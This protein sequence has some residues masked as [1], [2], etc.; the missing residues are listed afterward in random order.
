LKIVK[1]RTSL[2]EGVFR[3]LLLPCIVLVVAAGLVSWETLRIEASVA[4]EPDFHDYYAV[5]EAKYRSH[6]TRLDSCTVCH[7]V[8][9]AGDPTGMNAYGSDLLTELQ[10]TVPGAAFTS[11]PDVEPP[12]GAGSC[13]D[14]LDN[15]G[16]TDIDRDDSDCQGSVEIGTDLQGDAHTIIYDALNAIAD[17]DSD[18]DGQPN[19][20][21]ITAL[22][23]PGDGSD[24]FEHVPAAPIAGPHG[25][26]LTDGPSYNYAPFQCATCH[27]TH[28]AEAPILLTSEPWGTGGLCYTCHSGVGA[29]TDVEDGVISSGVDAGSS[30]HGGGLVNAVMDTDVNGVEHPVSAPVTSTH[31][32]DGTPGLMWGSLSEEQDASGAGKINVTLDC[33]NCHDPH[34]AAIGYGENP[35][36]NDVTGDIDFA[37]ALADG[38]VTLNYRMLQPSPRESGGYEETMPYAPGRIPFMMAVPDGGLSGGSYTQSYYAADVTGTAHDVVRPETTYQPN[39][40]LVDW[41][42]I[43]HTRYQRVTVTQYHNGSADHGAITERLD[44]GPGV[45][46]DSDPIFTYGH[47]TSE[48]TCSTVSGCH[49]VGGNMPGEDYPT[50]FSRPRCLDC[51]VSHGTSAGQFLPSCETCHKGYDE[52][53]NHPG[54]CF[55]CHE[56]GLSSPGPN[57]A[58]WPDFELEDWYDIVS[59]WDLCIACHWPE[60]GEGDPWDFLGSEWANH[61]SLLRSDNRGVCTT[62]HQ[63]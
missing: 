52:P 41:C 59:S 2:G 23:F 42:S 34:G 33:G 30:I 8:D 47:A 22:S 36:D 43:C 54:E 32:V 50:A 46:A 48:A 51:H 13:N 40:R 38:R 9:G 49:T 39:D 26:Y 31:T 62:C 45:P 11:L 15:D 58:A 28:T 20:Y 16:D 19:G 61:S 21:E 4:T 12:G 5:F 6:N 57:H 63:K 56:G 24:F 53:G 10:V 7:T 44:A 55:D 60:W 14:A 25:G 35:L 37:D 3:I 17:A 18:S 1:T 27:R 29:L